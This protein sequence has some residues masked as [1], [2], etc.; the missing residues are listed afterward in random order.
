MQWVRSS[1]LMLLVLGSAG[2]TNSATAQRCVMGLDANGN[3]NGPCQDWSSST[4]SYDRDT[5]SD[6]SNGKNT[7]FL[8]S[9]FQFPIRAFAAT[10]AVPF[11]GIYAVQG[12]GGRCFQRNVDG[13]A[14]TFPPAKLVPQGTSFFGQPA[15]PPNVQVNSWTPTTATN[16]T[17]SAQA[18]SVT[19][20]SRS[21]ALTPSSENARAQAGY[22]FETN[23]SASSAPVSFGSVGTQLSPTVRSVNALLMNDARYRADLQSHKA[24]LAAAANDRTTGAARLNALQAQIA[25]DRNNITRNQGDLYQYV[26]QP[27]VAQQVPPALQQQVNNVLRY[28]LD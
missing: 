7:N 14:N 22:G 10:V 24:A 27:A 19:R 23:P 11:C 28:Q 4:S 13:L 2:F 5:Y 8:Q 9:L 1:A 15:T 3:P 25:T 12:D 26:R 18:V 6:P 17:S 21:A 16:P 20:D